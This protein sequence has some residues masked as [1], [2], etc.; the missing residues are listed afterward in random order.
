M[1]VALVYQDYVHSNGVLLKRLQDTAGITAIRFV[2]AADIKSG[3]LRDYVNALFIMPGGADLFYC[4]KL[5]GAGNKAIHD[6]VE[7]GG[8]YLGLCAGAYYGCAALDWAARE[9]HPIAGKRELAFIDTTATGPVY[10]L[11]ENGDFNKSWSSIAQ[12]EMNGALYPA[13]YEGGPV[14]DTRDALGRYTLPGNPP[15]ILRQDFGKGCVILSSPHIEY[16]P[17]YLESALYNH[18]QASPD[19]MQGVLK[20]FKQQWRPELDLWSKIVSPLLNH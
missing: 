10:D 20:T 11:I 5:N 8:I 1:T 9:E 19:Y 14:F 13:Y 7:A 2:D 3:T 15:A 16:T 4:E 6:F 17:D 18:R 12:V